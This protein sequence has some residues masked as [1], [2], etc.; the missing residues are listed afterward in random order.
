MDRPRFHRYETMEDPR[1][2]GNLFFMDF[3][4]ASAVEFEPAI[5]L[6]VSLSADALN[7]VSLYF[8]RKIWPIYWFF[9]VR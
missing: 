2:L 9:K 5:M 1:I 3:Y 8:E 6:V 4:E 7:G